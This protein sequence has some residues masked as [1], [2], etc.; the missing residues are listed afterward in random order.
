MNQ[1]TLRHFL[2]KMGM[3]WGLLIVVFTLFAVS[4]EAP[5]A[6]A[7]ARIA[8]TT[9]DGVLPIWA[10]LNVGDTVVSPGRGYVMTL[11]NDGNLVERTGGGAYVWSS[12]STG[13]G[14]QGRDNVRYD[15]TMQGDG[16]FVIYCSGTCGNG[17]PIFSTYTYCRSNS[18]L[19]VQ[20]DGNIVVYDPN[21]IA[22]WARTW[23]RNYH[24]CR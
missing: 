5:A 23:N 16:N 24:T 3:L 6:H 15:A 7:Q 21:H 13:H 8:S 10:T 11:Q 4:N 14:I 17:F 9:Y 2:R 22:V 12:L 19:E 1:R 18:H 20:V